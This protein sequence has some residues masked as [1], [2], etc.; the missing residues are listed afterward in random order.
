MYDG[1]VSSG[2]I[3]VHLS[4]V[5]LA[6]TEH[7]VVDTTACYDEIL[8]LVQLEISLRSLEL[9]YNFFFFLRNWST[10]TEGP[11]SPLGGGP[12]GLG[13]EESQHPR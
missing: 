3:V 4:K 1:E 7:C 8:G 6:F 13:Q 2:T 9:E 11:F 5:Q 10:I 12:F